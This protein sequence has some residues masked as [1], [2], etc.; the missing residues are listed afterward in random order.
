MCGNGRKEKGS[1]MKA[2]QNKPRR[3]KD[4]R[5]NEGGTVGRAAESQS[6]MGAQLER[7]GIV[8]RTVA[9]YEWGGFR[10]TNASDAVAAAKRAEAA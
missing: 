5:E 8:S 2:P 4:R 6:D 1:E 3:A 9:I 7:Y 10:Y